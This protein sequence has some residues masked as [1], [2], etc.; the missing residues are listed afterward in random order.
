[1][2]AEVELIDYRN[3]AGKE[4]VVQGGLKGPELNVLDVSEKETLELGDPKE[5]TVIKQQRGFLQA[6]ATQA[7][8]GLDF[9][10]NG[11]ASS[12]GGRQHLE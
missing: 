8:V 5:K 3:L 12:R 9:T 4:E 1:M 10:P 11:R 6:R 2:R 7:F